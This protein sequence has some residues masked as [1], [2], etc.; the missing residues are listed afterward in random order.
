MKIVLDPGHGGEHATG[1]STPYGARGPS[2]AL[3]RDVV[4]RLSHMVAAELGGAATL[5]RYGNGENPSLAARAELARRSGAHVFVSLH[6]GDRGGSETWVH[7]QAGPRSGS[8]AGHIQRTLGGTVRQGAL[9]VLDPNRHA[10]G[11][12]ACLIEVDALRDAYGGSLDAQARAIAQGI[13]AYGQYDNWFNDPVD[14]AALDAQLHD[15]RG[16]DNRRVSQPAAAHAVV[17][18]LRNWSG[19]SPWRSLDRNTVCLRLDQLID[20]PKLVQQGPTPL[21]GP[22][23]FFTCWIKRDPVAFARFAKTLFQTGAS[24]IGTSY[25]VRPGQVLLGQDYGAARTANGRSDFP[26]QADWMVMGAIRNAEDEIFIWDGVVRSGVENDLRGLTFPEE[27]ARW[28][29]ATGIY[30]R[31]DNQ[32]GTGLSTLTSKGYNAAANI[33]QRPGRDVVCLIQSNGFPQLNM[34]HTPWPLSMF[35]NHFVV[36]NGLVHVVNERAPNPNS[37]LPVGV[38]NPRPLGSVTFPIW[39]FGANWPDLLSPSAEAFASAFFGGIVADL[40]D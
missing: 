37:P 19:T 31:V 17:T 26:A 27:I 34:G 10:R 6:A 5:T 18:E 21:C 3:E 40:R 36:L 25:Q 38:A 23:S 39:T 20:D 35:S 9:G 32:I 2:G 28:F 30:S 12:A 7:Q 14:N 13:R 4:L 11:T 29:N 16:A 22:A 24:Q 8:L 33:T 1:R 15:P